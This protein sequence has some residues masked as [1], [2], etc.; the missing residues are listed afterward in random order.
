MSDVDGVDDDVVDGGRPPHRPPLT[1]AQRRARRQAITLL[2]VGGLLLVSF[3][4]AAAYYGGWFS[5]PKSKAATGGCSTSTATARSKL[6]PSQVHVNVYN[7]S[8][9]NGLA[10][11]VSGEMKLQG[12]VTGKVANDPLKADVKTPAQIRYG[13]KGKAGAQLVASEVP[14]SKMVLDKRKDATVD[15]VLGATYS[16]LSASTATSAGSTPTCHPTTTGTSTATST[17]S[18]TTS[19]KKP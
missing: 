18:P 6:A 5:T 17:G 16:K 10:K 3:L 11:K 4:F 7:A 2:L 9:R 15:L 14:G 13:A 8:K 12:F 1:P 19:K